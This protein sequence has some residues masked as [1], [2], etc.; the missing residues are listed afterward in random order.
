MRL[1]QANGATAGE[2][3]AGSPRPHSHQATLAFSAFTWIRWT[4]KPTLV[5]A[6]EEVKAVKAGLLQG[7]VHT[8]QGVYEDYSKTV[9]EKQGH[10]L[11]PPEGWEGEPH[12]DVG[13][14]ICW[15][16]P[17]KADTGDTFQV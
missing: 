11:N 10:W 13:Q 4:E 12:P 6:V 1:A 15:S 3:Q 8:G 9:A 7:G 17:I 2:G 14:T 5:V 16:V